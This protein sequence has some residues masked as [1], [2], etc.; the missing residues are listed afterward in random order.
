[1]STIPELAPVLCH[2]IA[3]RE[4]HSSLL[5]MDHVCM[6]IWRPVVLTLSGQVLAHCLVWEPPVQDSLP[7]IFAAIPYEVLWSEHFSCSW[8]L[9]NL[10]GANWAAMGD[11]ER[12]QNRQ[13]DRKIGA[14][15]SGCS[16]GDTQQP[17]CFSLSLFFKALL[18]YSSLKPCF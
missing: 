5:H 1:M 8:L 18:L 15:C 6:I 13:T 14:R 3:T 16:D 9:L 11:A 7:G 17:H 2:L 10:T 4:S 12:T